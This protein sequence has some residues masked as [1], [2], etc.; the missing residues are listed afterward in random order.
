MTIP[1][2]ALNLHVSFWG[3]RGSIST[4]G[5]TT[6]KYGGNTPCVS[7]RHDDTIIVFD[8]GTGIRN[9]GLDLMPEIKKGTIKMP[10]HL[11]LSHTHWDHIQGLPFFLPAY[12]PGVKLVIHGSAHKGGFLE[13]ILQGQMDYDY[14]PVN[15][16][17][18][19]AEITIHEMHEPTIAIGPMT[20]AWQEQIYHPGGCVRYK[21][22]LDGRSVVYASDIE[23]N[24]MFDVVDPT[25]DVAE[26]ANVYRN[27][28]RNAE[29]LIGDGQ[30]LED[31][32]KK[33]VG[34][35][36]TT[37]P[38]LIEVAYNQ[39]VKQ[40]ALFHH[41]P[42]RTDKQIDDLWKAYYP[43]FHD[44]SPPMNVFWAREGMTIPV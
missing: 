32:Y 40:L 12:V 42:T 34:W 44:A 24:K 5:R 27:F 35:G 37:M 36:H 29:L 4:P 30:Y 3:T 21:V 28:V 11:F 20:V 7:V 38:L 13:S 17:A 39:G 16:S 33:V 43:R 25:E 10:I 22:T 18:F 9:L 6:E 19:G 2:S 23:L 31:E 15:M 1:T 26:H 14:F 41:D 8:A